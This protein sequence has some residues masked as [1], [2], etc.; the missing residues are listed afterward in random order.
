MWELQ[1]LL[2]DSDRDFMGR[3]LS[4]S[5]SR[6]EFYGKFFES[7]SL[8]FLRELLY[9]GEVFGSDLELLGEC[10]G[11]IKGLFQGHFE[12]KKRPH[13]V[14]NG[15]CKVL[16]SNLFLEFQRMPNFAFFKGLDD[17]QISQKHIVTLYG[18]YSSNHYL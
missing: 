14:Q 9:D 13:I 18:H 8:F 17:A 15:R 16:N 12:N 3:F 2:L 1:G 7:P 6:R 11:E 5:P 10:V 4:P